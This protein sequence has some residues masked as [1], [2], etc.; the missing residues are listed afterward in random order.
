MKLVWKLAAPQSKVLVPILSVLIL[1]LVLI[2][3]RA[4]SVMRDSTYTLVMLEMKDTADFVNHQ[5]KQSEEITNS[6]L[7]MMNRKNVALAQALALIIAK[8]PDSLRNENMARLCV[9]FG[10]AEVHVTDKNGIL[11]WGSEPRFFG[12]DFY[13]NDQTRPITAIIDDP[14]LTI[15]QNSQPRAADGTLFQYINVSRIDQPGIVQVGV[16]MKTINYIKSILNVQNAI[17]DI[18][19]GHGGGVFLMNPERQL[20]AK[21]SHTMFG[22]DLTNQTWADTMFSQKEG[23]LTLRYNNIDY[24]SYY[25]QESDCMIVTYIPLSEMNGYATKIFYSILPFGIG[26]VL[27]VSIISV[28]L[29]RLIAGKAYWYESILDCIPFLIS[30][31]DMKRNLTFINKPVEVFFGEKRANLLGKPCSNWNV[32]ICNS[33]KCGINCLENGKQTT[34]FDQKGTKFKVDVN[35]LTD[36]R[37]RKTG[38][39]E[40]VQD[41]TELLLL[42]EKL[43]SALEEAKAAS[44]AK[45]NFLANMS[46][47]IRTPMN[48]IIGMTNIGKS[49]NDI[50]RK[51]YSLMRIEDASLHLLGVINDILDVSKIESGKFVLSPAGFNFEKMLIRVVN[52]SNFRVDEKKQQF[53]V[54]VD[55]KIPQYMTGDENRLAQVIT[56]LLGN[57]VKFTP[58]NGSIKLNTYFIKEE[59]DICEIKI[60][61]TDTG[62]GMSRAQQEHLFESFYQAE[63]SMSR[64]FGGT[65]LGLV[66]SKKIVEMMDGRIWIES[67]LGKGV[68]V[69]FT[70]KMQRGEMK[71]YESGDY[72]IDWKNIR[73][74][75]VDDD[76]NILQDFKG[77]VEKF[78]A[79]CDVADNGADALKL[80]EQNEGYNLFFLDW[81][82]P[83][84]D[85]IKLA[86]ELKKRISKTGNSFIVMS[87][88]A[89]SSIFAEKAKEAGVDSF[90]Q[91]PLFPST[92]ADVVAECFRSAKLQSDDAGANIDGIFKGRRILLSEDVQ[93]NREI[94]KTILEPTLLEIDCAENGREAVQMFG[95]ASDK[96]ELIFMDIQMPEM[97]GYEAT[98]QIR[99]LDVPNAKSIPIIAM[100][101]NVFKED[102]ENCFAAGMNGHVGKPLDI[103]EVI[104]KLR[105]CLN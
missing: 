45:S 25:R 7:E 3:I 32:N 61:I 12:L 90:L 95:T 52:I 92:I 93:I 66:I 8:D 69:A 86:T 30:V 85:G 27:I 22:A 51:H 96:Y 77:I 65:G 75:S 104:D 47:E 9:L 6:A 10:V 102:I 11:R 97:D 5:I 33:D 98:R 18:K 2:S 79:Y 94:V 28:W 50:E 67:E 13:A 21:S 4:V 73:I 48:A 76:K 42:Q 54:Y 20:V 84:M 74:L 40:I 43:E 37:K 26:A 46:H 15:A 62:I 14:S 91:K 81:R 39:I 78:G 16:E 35:Y 44:N 72:K 105:E 83:G 38:H 59:N 63:S 41:V 57:A 23:Y 29:I 19:I 1:S 89:E 49:A 100:S 24:D 87:S 60:T 34:T 99:A 71:D 68:M 31:T 53:T 88:A 36:K 55:R 17:D 58:E 70:V 103:N 80:I 56:N 101:A 82:M 64:K